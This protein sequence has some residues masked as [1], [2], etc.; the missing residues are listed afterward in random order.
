MFSQILLGDKIEK[1]EMHS[2]FSLNGREEKFL[3][4]IDIY[5]F[6]MPSCTTQRFIRLLV[7]V[8]IQAID[9]STTWKYH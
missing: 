5:L 9:C 2:A 1:D 7:S 4:N 8:Y 6:N 3:N